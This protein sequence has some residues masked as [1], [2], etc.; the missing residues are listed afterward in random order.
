VD[1]MRPGCGRLTDWPPPLQW[2]KYLDFRAVALRTPYLSPVPITL[3]R[4]IPIE[5]FYLELF[6][7]DLAF[8]EGDNHCLTPFLWWSSLLQRANQHLPQM[9]C[10]PFLR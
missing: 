2:V 5:H 9:L 3:I 4:I 6:S 8:H 1:A 10:R 7:T